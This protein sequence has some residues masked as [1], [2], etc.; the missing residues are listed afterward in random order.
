MDHDPLQPVP[1]SEVPA[2]LLEAAWSVF[3]RAYAPYS[4]FS[5]GAALRDEQG[6]VH[7]GANVENGSYGLSR[8]AE[9]SAVQTMASS[10]GRRVGE[11]VVVAKAEPAATPCGACRQVLA[12]FGPE[13]RVY[14]VNEHGA[15]RTSVAALLPAGF[16]LRP[17][18]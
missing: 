1:L 5:V 17:L 7:V 9:Q 15:W 13:A 18:A 8:C 14:L 10:G 12:E 4:G 2:D 16:R 6:R 3:A 11:V